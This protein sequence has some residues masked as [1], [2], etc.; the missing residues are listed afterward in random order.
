[1]CNTLFSETNQFQRDIM[2]ELKNLLRTYLDGKVPR[3]KQALYALQYLMHKM[4]H[5]N[6]K[7]CCIIFRFI[8]IYWKNQTLQ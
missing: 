8:K 5:P 2:N 7:C 6:S 1:M 4:E 3:E